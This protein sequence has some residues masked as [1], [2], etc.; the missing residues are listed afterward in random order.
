MSTPTKTRR[1]WSNRLAKLA[2]AQQAAQEDVLVGIFLARQD[3][4]PQQVIADALP[5]VS[6]SGVAAKTRKG[7]EIMRRRKGAISP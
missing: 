5:G 7:E 1:V 3:G 4:V 6:A 2:A